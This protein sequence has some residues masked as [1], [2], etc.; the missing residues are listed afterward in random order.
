MNAS[1][2][3]Q[4]AAAAALAL[5]APTAASAA[6]TAYVA[7]PVAIA[8]V[9]DDTNRLN[10]P[11]GQRDL[12]F[13]ALSVSFVNRSNVAATN[14][15]FAITRDGKTQ[16]FAQHGSYAPGTRID[17]ELAQDTSTL[18]ASTA[19]VKIAKVDFA[20]GTSWTPR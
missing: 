16:L 15:E 6:Q 20:D 9:T 13:N 18:P 19:T 17:R 2:R 3:I 5:A 11:Y 1:T 10:L 8:G 7:S 14:V 4:L 12:Y